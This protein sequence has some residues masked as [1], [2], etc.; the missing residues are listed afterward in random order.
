[1]S[2]QTAAARQR[3]ALV[4]SGTRIRVLPALFGYRYWIRRIGFSKEGWRLTYDGAWKAAY[5][6]AS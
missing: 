2:E 5:R 4:G 6:R 3:Y 1:M